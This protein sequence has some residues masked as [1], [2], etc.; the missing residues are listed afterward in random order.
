[1]TVALDGGV[2]VGRNLTYIDNT[3]NS[4]NN[5]KIGFFGSFESNNDSRVSRALIEHSELWLVRRGMEKIRGPI[6]PIAEHWGFLHKTNGDPPIFLSPHNPPYYV[7]LF[8]DLGYSKVKDLLT[9]DVNRNGTYEIPE[10]IVRFTTLLRERRPGLSTRRINSRRIMQDAEI[11]WRISNN[12][13]AGNWGY[14]PVNRHV[15]VDLVRRLRLIMDPDAIWFVEDSGIPVGYCL[16]YPDINPLIKK[17]DGRLLPFGFTK[18]L[19]GLKKI[20]DYRLFGFAIEPR[21]QGM[22]LDVLLYA[23]LFHALK[24]KGIR[25]EANYILE[26]NLNMRNAL[27]KLGMDRI[28]TYRILEKEL[29]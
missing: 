14:V 11:I 16:G 28:R 17:I 23:E 21:Y 22:G 13:Y 3:Y 7:E 29:S 18:L 27:E 9:Y 1:M 26:D 5:T 4:Y 15:M 12:A 2:C 6:N 10:R 8:S 25:L 19:F 24:P 20:K